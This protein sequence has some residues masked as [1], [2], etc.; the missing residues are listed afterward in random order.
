MKKKR[1]LNEKKKDGFVVALAIEGKEI[2]TDIQT[3][4]WMDGWMDEQT[5]RWTDGPMDRKTDG[6]MDR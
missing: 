4:R 5:E 1:S 3:D 2:E 6:Q